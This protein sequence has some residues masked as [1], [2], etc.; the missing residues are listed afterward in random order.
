[1]DIHAKKFYLISGCRR[2]EK[3]TL[4]CWSVCRSIPG[5]RATRI[6]PSRRLALGRASLHAAA[7]NINRSD[8]VGESRALSGGHFEVA[9]D[10]A[11]VTRDGEFQILLSCRDGFVLNLSFVLEDPQCR[12]VVL[13]LLKA[14]AARRGRHWVQTT[15]LSRSVAAFGLLPAR[16]GMAPVASARQEPMQ[17]CR[18][19]VAPVT[20]SKSL[21]ESS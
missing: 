7:E 8:F 11:L 17:S 9:G 15:L 1:V 21:E 20:S 16:N 13:N 18:I 19:I 12:Y 6:D 14:G 2:Q 3:I 5:V 4:S 10:A